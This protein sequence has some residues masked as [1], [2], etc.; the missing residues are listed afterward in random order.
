MTSLEALD[1]AITHLK[2]ARVVVRQDE[3]VG[4]ALLR[5]QAR[6]QAIAALEALRE[7]IDADE[8]S[9]RL[10]RAIEEAQT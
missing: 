7:Q 1:Y 3:A 8:S 10:F 4:A 9:A 5:D 2:S 6:L